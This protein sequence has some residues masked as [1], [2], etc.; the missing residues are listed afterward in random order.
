MGLVKLLLGL[1][2]LS[3]ALFASA[4]SLAQDAAS[5]PRASLLE[6]L[7]DDTA[8][9]ALIASLEEQASE[10]TEAP[11]EGAAFEDASFGRQIAEVTTD[12]ARTA[13]DQLANLWDGI[14]TAP[15][16]LLSLQNVEVDLI[17]DAITDLAFVV[18]ATVATYLLLGWLGRKLIQRLVKAAQQRRWAMRFVFAVMAAGIELV[19]VL[20]AGAVGYVLTTAFSDGFGSIAV[21]QALYLNAFVVV[22]VL[23]VAVRAILAPDFAALRLLTL[24]T[25]AVRKLWR[26][27]S[28]S[29]FVVGYGYLLVVPIVNSAAGRATGNAVGMAIALVVVAAA[30]RLVLRHRKAVAGWLHT[31]DST[32]ER[33]TAL[34]QLADLW[35]WP[36]LLYL[37]GVLLVVLTGPGDVLLQ[38]LYAS[39]TVLAVLVVGLF[40][41]TELSEIAGRGLRLPFPVTRR[42]PLLENRLN[43]FVPNMLNL[44]RILI[45]VAVA[46]TTLDILGV[47]DFST[48]LSSQTGIEF[49]SKTLSVLAML[50]V[51]GVLWLALTSWVD[52]RLN[53]HFGSVP[54]ARETT[55]LS[56]LRNAATIALVIITSMFV[57]SEVGIDIAP[58]L[59]SAGVLGLAIGFGAQK[60][61]QDIITGIFIQLENAMNVGDVVT[62]GG[63]TGVV[64]K[65]TVRSVSLRDVEGAFHIIPFSSV[66]MVSNFTRDFAYFLCDMG[67]AYDS[68]PDLVKQA[69]M[70]A[71]ARLKEDP[72]FG[73]YI[74]GELEWFG[75]TTFGDS[76]I[77]LRGRIKTTPG[78]QWGIGRAY[79]AIVK[80]VFDARGIEIP[81]PHRFIIHKTEALEQPTPTSE[82]PA[83]E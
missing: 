1:V 82:A 67:V 77:T 16:A 46:G 51:A 60:L 80:R 23:R 9:E 66:D 24:P 4:P 75:L 71:F 39:G 50:F 10:A 40:I 14:S 28:F 8:R 21:R 61:V 22:Q 17:V 68:D 37:I 13:A 18:L 44:L 62:V 70:D 36:V 58:L 6:I 72:E 35:H 47:F 12:L 15:M 45:L 49:T 19:V 76:A 48:W 53:P 83:V 69:M 74:L 52:F 42:L 65:L 26:Y 30:L 41:S 20:I 54:S 25:P 55:L 59:A 79:N 27:L 34:E 3:G 7:K 33:D 73:P 32:R 64:E 63:T 38:L 31:N 78:R 56:L 43:S 2:F 11:T 81:Y 5:D 29:I 57:L